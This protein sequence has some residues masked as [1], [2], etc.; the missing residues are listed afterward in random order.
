MALLSLIISGVQIAFTVFER[1]YHQNFYIARMIQPIFYVALLIILLVF[2]TKACNKLQEDLK[3]QESKFTE[4]SK[5][6]LLK[7]SKTIK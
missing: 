4:Q 7:M 1:S 5:T 3:E 2:S 6:L